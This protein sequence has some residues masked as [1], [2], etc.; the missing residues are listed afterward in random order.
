M[1]KY[2]V[3]NFSVDSS[4]GRLNDLAK[5]KCLVAND[6]EMQLSMLELLLQNAEFE[7]LKA[8]NGFE[9]IE[10]YQ[11]TLMKQTR[12]VDLIILDLM[13]PIT[14]GYEAIERITTLFE[15]SKNSLTFSEADDP[16]SPVYKNTENEKRGFKPI[17]IACSGLINQEV[18]A[19]TKAAGFDTLL[20][21]PIS[22]AQI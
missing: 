8:R 21:V 12:P 14:D 20:Q 2:L 9:A 4:E 18:M 6:D 16:T 10:K 1:A 19:K 15:N 7:V 13:M 22:A 3:G 5:Y 17:I 11:D